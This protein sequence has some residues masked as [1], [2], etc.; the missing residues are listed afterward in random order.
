MKVLSCGSWNFFKNTGRGVVWVEKYCHSGSSCL[1][2]S[3]KFLPLTRS[4]KKAKLFTL[5]EGEGERKGYE[6]RPVTRRPFFKWN[7]DGLSRRQRPF[8]LTTSR[9]ERRLEN[10][11]TKLKLF[12]FRSERAKTLFLEPSS[13][14]NSGRC[15]SI[16]GL[17]KRATT[18]TT[19][20]TTKTTTTK[21]SHT[22]RTFDA[23]FG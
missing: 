23:N 19:T 8:G 4:G 6:E 11:E 22:V 17:T 14:T 10:V 13:F 20:S 9:R 7:L 21:E 3:H 18:T 12:L 2:F 1:Y 15:R 16:H 5:I